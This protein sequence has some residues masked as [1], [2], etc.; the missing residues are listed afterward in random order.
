MAIAPRTFV[1]ALVAGACCALVAADSAEGQTLASVR[2]AGILAVAPGALPDVA[3]TVDAGPSP[4]QAFPASRRQRSQGTSPA[5]RGAAIGIVAAAGITALAAA[6]H[7]QNE[8][9]SFCG[10][11]FVRWSLVTVPVG[12]GAGAAIGWGVGRARR[13]VA[14]VP[15]FSP[16]AAGVAVVA[17][18]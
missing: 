18:F 11:C 3:A 2:S 15:L 7:G 17:T 4:A 12:A 5:A 8:K 1:L 14:A 13:S 9:G 6:Q 10:A 16:N